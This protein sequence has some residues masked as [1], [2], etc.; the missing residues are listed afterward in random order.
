MY[1]FWF[2]CSKIIHYFLVILNKLYI[3]YL[4]IYL[5]ISDPVSSF[6]LDNI[7][8]VS[9][10][11][12][13]RWCTDLIFSWF[14]FY[15][16]CTFSLRLS[17]ARRVYEKKKLCLLLTGNNL[18]EIF[19]DKISKVSSFVCLFS[20][21]RRTLFSGFLDLTSTVLIQSIYEWMN[22]RTHNLK[23]LLLLL[24][25]APTPQFNYFY[26]YFYWQLLHMLWA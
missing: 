6:L 23:A 20:V 21:R 25:L 1:F 13:S 16:F 3:S 4:F 18:M 7:T 2:I 12:L 22:I 10:V 24:L 14:I 11:L 19:D 9:R 5:F 8:F 26:Y 15:F 17:F